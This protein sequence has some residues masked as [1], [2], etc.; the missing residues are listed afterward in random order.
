MFTTRCNLFLNESRS[1]RH[2][3]I[4]TCCFLFGLV[5]YW[6]ICSGSLSVRFGWSTT[7][8]CNCAHLARSRFR[9]VSRRV[10]LRFR[11][12]MLTFGRNNLVPAVGCSLYA[13]VYR[14]VEVACRSGLL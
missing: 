4:A 10:L 2:S 3:A 9:L 8:T 12:A 5:L 11:S 6:T 7:S 1:L 13:G 14:S